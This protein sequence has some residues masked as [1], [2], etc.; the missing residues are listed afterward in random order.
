[1]FARTSRHP[2]VHELAAEGIELTAFDA[3]YD[4]APSLDD[5][6]ARIVGGLVEAAREAVATGGEAMAQVGGDVGGEGPGQVAYAVPGSAVVAERTVALLHEAARA[7]VV[8]VAVVPGLSFADLAWARLG[9][10]PMAT[11]AS[12]VDGR[13]LD[14]YDVSGPMLIAQ[15]DTALVLSDVKLT[16]L[17]R[18]APDFPVVVVHHLGLADE[19]VVH[20]SLAEL[21]HLA[22]A[23]GAPGRGSPTHAW[24][25]HLTSVF[26]DAPPG[27][28]AALRE[29]LR[30][31]RRLR[32]P[33]G[34]PWDAEQTHRSLARYVL[35]EAY[36]VV[37]VLERLPIDAPGGADAVEPAQYAQLVDEL[38]DL[39]Y[40]VVFHVLLAEEGA[41]FHF[42]DA[43]RA[44]T[45]SSCAAIPM[46]SATSTS[47]APPT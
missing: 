9:I 40:Q 19:L 41:G 14:R 20:R 33:G 47:K 7:G 36:E 45:T 13:A 12:V 43:A 46:C 39:L 27:D 16:L 24:P 5:A 32:D 34:C 25:D 22:S 4:A 3:I 15:C 11:G 21:D 42:A 17:E 26:V 10:D 31:A 35:E 2:A 29:L 28:A 1:M 38:G 8:D 30:L 6:Y 23:D 37:E 44:S 18:L